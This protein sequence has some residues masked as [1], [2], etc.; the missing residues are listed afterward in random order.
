MTDDAKCCKY[1]SGKR[2]LPCQN[3]VFARMVC[4]I[5]GN[6]VWRLPKRHV[7]FALQARLSAPE[8]MVL[9]VLLQAFLQEVKS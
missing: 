8:S 2:N 1:F 6:D 9:Y 4:R 7:E 5:S 3:R